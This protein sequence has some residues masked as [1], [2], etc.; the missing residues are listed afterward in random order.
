VEPDKT[1]LIEQKKRKATRIEC[2]NILTL[3]G[4]CDHDA[5]ELTMCTQPSRSQIVR[6]HVS[7]K[8]F[9]TPGVQ[10]K[11]DF[12]ENRSQIHIYHPFRSH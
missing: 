8:A 6:R 10:T 2:S 11:H 12:R 4:S 9:P 3:T 7:A 5:T 1:C